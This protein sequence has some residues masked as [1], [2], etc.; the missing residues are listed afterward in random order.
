MIETIGVE[1]WVKPL[2][3]GV[4]VDRRVVKKAVLEI[5]NEIAGDNYSWA[6]NLIYPVLIKNMMNQ[7]DEELASRVDKIINAF[8]AYRLDIKLK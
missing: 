6:I 3:E 7:S 4:I 2:S 8:D 1:T 5:M